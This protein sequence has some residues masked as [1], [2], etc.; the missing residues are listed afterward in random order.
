[1]LFY[2]SL[3]S[4][5]W[6]HFFETVF[7][8]RFYW[9]DTS[10]SLQSSDKILNHDSMWFWTIIDDSSFVKIVVWSVHFQFFVWRKYFFPFGRCFTRFE[11]F[12]A[13]H[14]WKMFSFDQTFSSIMQHFQKLFSRIYFVSNKNALWWMKV[15]MIVEDVESHLPCMTILSES[16]A[17]P[18]WTASG[19]HISVRQPQFF[20]SNRFCVNENPAK[21]REE[22]EAASCGS[23]CLFRIFSRILLWCL[24]CFLQK[25]FFGVG[26]FQLQNHRRPSGMI[27]GQSA[28]LKTHIW[29]CR[30]KTS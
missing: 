7:P 17:H 9:C 2:D 19:V 24:D 28:L 10:R 4:M 25:C 14:N 30:Q 26:V 1:M 29:I 11:S 18:Q 3:H 16:V 27:L 8:R 12:S 5:F 15:I 22:F 6:L 20:T 13:R 21:E 23:V